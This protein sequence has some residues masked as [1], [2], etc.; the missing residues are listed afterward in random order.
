[1]KMKLLRNAAAAFTTMILLACG[2]GG[3][4][5][6]VGGGSE[7]ELPEFFRVVN[8]APHADEVTVT[9]GE[10]PLTEVVPYGEATTYVDIAEGTNT[11]RVRKEEEVL[12]AI[13][14]D[15]TVA[16][17]ASS[18]YLITETE[19]RVLEATTLAD[20]LERPKGGV[21]L[22][23]FINAGTNTAA[24]FYL[25]LPGED[26]DDTTAAASAVAFKGASDYVQVD[27]GTF[28]IHVT[29]MDEDRDLIE[30]DDATFDEAGIYTVIFL[31]KAGGGKP[32]RLLVL[33][34][35]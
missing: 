3:G 5:A 7:E 22:V 4:V 21:F 2:G 12:P 30:S 23:R 15:L 8:G 13:K 31:E 28:R 11:I 14:E 16:S 20:T 1:M 6:G 29:E 24:D 10:E 26:S 35:I 19:D 9:L 17:G 34:D 33:R 27:P 18:T 32:F 25:T